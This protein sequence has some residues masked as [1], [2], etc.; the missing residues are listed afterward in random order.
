LAATSDSATRR[1]VDRGKVAAA[2]SPAAQEVRS[3]A[4]IIGKILE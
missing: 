4:E 1:A 3:S 2:S